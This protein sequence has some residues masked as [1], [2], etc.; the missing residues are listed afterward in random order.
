MVA[1]VKE[2]Q[3]FIELPGSKTASSQKLFVKDYSML[4]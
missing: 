2:T 1:R 4:V 3:L